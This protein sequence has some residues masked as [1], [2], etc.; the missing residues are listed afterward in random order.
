MSITIKDVKKIAKLSRLSMDD[1]KAT[2]LQNDLNK[3]FH[4]IEQLNEVD[5]SKVAPMTG[6]E[7][8]ILPLRSDVVTEPNLQEKV[9]KNAPNTKY[10]YFVVPKVVE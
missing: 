7:E 6:V 4:W 3:I 2:K 8:Q 5:T 1:E 9:L 10:G